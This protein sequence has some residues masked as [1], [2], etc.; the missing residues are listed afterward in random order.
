MA[1][2]EVIKGLRESAPTLHEKLTKGAVVYMD[3]VPGGFKCSNCDYFH[4]PNSCELVEGNIEPEG[5]CNDF[6]PKDS[7]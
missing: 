2:T 1:K 6:K 3:P 4:Q 5:C 7:D